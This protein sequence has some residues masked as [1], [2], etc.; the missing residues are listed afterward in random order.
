MKFSHLFALLLFSLS[1]LSSAQIFEATGIGETPE[2]AKKDAVANAIKFSVGE[3]VVSKSELNNE[4]LTENIIGYSN[5]YV[6]KIEV[7]SQQ[8]NANEEY[9]VQVAVDIESQKLLDLIKEKQTVKATNVIDN[10]SLSQVA[11]YF[12]RNDLKKKNLEDFEALVDEL[13]VKPVLENKQVIDIEVVDKLKPSDL[14]NLA[15]GSTQVPFE[16]KVGLT[17]SKAYITGY[18]RILEEAKD[19]NGWVIREK[20]ITT[21]EVKRTYS[22]A[23]DK[24]SILYKKFRDDI[25]LS[26][27]F[28]YYRN[29]RYILFRFID[30]ENEMFEN[31]CESRDR[32]LWGEGSRD[33]EFYSGILY[34]TFKFYLNKEQIMR[35]KDIQISFTD[36]CLNYKYEGN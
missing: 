6:K 17:P 14:D 13:L 26:Y 19:D 10:E 11:N 18:K 36:R 23:S 16:L 25:G 12:E 2:L 33:E 32:L 9:E 7:L 21:Q 5:A 1:S 22:I 28:D 20:D 30:K 15:L 27:N 3:F 24:K 8:K 35:L 4:D 31:F 34:K 29:H